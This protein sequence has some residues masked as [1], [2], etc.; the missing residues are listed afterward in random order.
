MICL[1]SFKTLRLFKRVRARVRACVHVCPHVR[2]HVRLTILV[3]F[4]P[5][6]TVDH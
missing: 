2:V 6:T 4:R 5:R 3:Q 1:K